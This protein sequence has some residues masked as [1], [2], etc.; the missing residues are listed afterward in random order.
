MRRVLKHVSEHI[1]IFIGVFM[2]SILTLFILTLSINSFASDSIQ[3]EVSESMFPNM[4]TIGSILE[5]NRDYSLLSSSLG[6][7]EAVMDCETAPLGVLEQ[8][9]AQD[10]EI[11]TVLRCG[12]E[13]MI[14]LSKEDSELNYDGIALA[15]RK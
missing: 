4:I 12:D 5:L 15:L 9:Q 10:S 2:K 6:G 13:T 8:F 7:E 1:F 3:Y 14:I 11:S